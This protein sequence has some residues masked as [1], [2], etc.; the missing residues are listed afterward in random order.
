MCSIGQTPCCEAYLTQSEQLVV[1]YEV[2]AQLQDQNLRGFPRTLQEGV[3][4]VV[5]PIDGIAW[6]T[7]YLRP[8]TVTLVIDDAEARP[9]GLRY[10]NRQ[11]TTNSKRLTVKGNEWHHGAKDALSV[12]NAGIGLGSSRLKPSRIISLKVRLSWRT[13]YYTIMSRRGQF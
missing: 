5:L 10:S 11:G 1:R 9:V 13:P 8:E 7:R 4:M 3:R 6:E 12:W 2:L